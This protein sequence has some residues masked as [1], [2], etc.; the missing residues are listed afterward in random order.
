VVEGHNF[1]GSVAEGAPHGATLT[2]AVRS[3]T[4]LDAVAQSAETG[5]WVEVPA[6]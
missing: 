5:T 2:D 3:A 4:T 6:T 1:L